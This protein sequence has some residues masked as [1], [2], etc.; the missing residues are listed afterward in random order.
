MK[1]S[2]AAIAVVF[3][4][5]SAAWAMPPGTLTTLRA[6]QALSSAEADKGLPV[7]F[8]ATVT[9]YHKGAYTLFMQ[10]GGVGTFVSPK[11]DNVMLHPGD[12]VFVRG[13][14][15]GSFH[16]IVIS[17]NIT[18]LR[19]GEMPKPVPATFDELIRGQRDCLMV[20]VR[21]VIRA[22]DKKTD[23][24]DNYGANLQMLTEGGYIQVSVFNSTGEGLAD[25]LD[26]EVEV[27]GVA[28]GLFDGKMQAH[29][30]VI[31]VGTSADIKILKRASA[32]PWSLPVTP[33]GEIITGFHITDRTQ[34]VR[35]HG[36]ITY[37]QPGTSV[38][39]QDGASS[40]WI[41]TWTFQP[42]KVGDVVDATG[43]P[44]AHNGFLAVTRGEI[45]DSHIQAPVTPLPTT[46]KQLTQ[47]RH[48]IDLVSLEARV[49][50]EARGGSQDE[51]DLTA[52][53]QLF[54]AI[55][56]H[57]GGDA[58][59]PPMK[60]I[61]IGS[62]VR[63]T[64]ICITEDSNPFNSDVGFDILMRNFDDITVV[65][66]PS[67]INT[68]NLVVAISLLLI[69]VIAVGAWGWFLRKRVGQ[70]TATLASM[71][72][73]EQR[74]SHILE[75]ING[76]APLAEILKDIS[77][78]VSAMLDG[79]LCWCEMENE[80]AAGLRP[81]HLDGMRVIQT[82]I[83]GH[84]SALLGKFFAAFDA[85]SPRSA[86]E[87]EALSVGVRLASLAIET[88]KLFSDL[89]RRSEFDLLTEI[90]NRFSLEKSLTAQIEMAQANNSVFGLIYIDLDKFKQINDRYGHHIGDL[91]L[92]ESARRMKNQLRGGD[93]LARLG[94]DE[95]AALVSV[96]RKRAEA[97]EIA[98]R[99]ERCF[100]EPFSLEGNLI[101]GSA[102]VG[103]A[104]YPEDG[105]TGDGLLSAADDAMYAV[106]RGK[107]QIEQSL[108]PLSAR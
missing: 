60:Q 39:L 53:G 106:K 33:M 36:T 59:P 21:G 25:L 107:R 43:F 65:A 26:A 6:I 99:M 1:R 40:L 104:L 10:D 22:G 94:G 42:M 77:G 51:Y 15:A 58:A 101:H 74:R 4:F 103:F 16:P 30:V 89:R 66:R 2:I 54:S 93:V 73:F 44:E 47:S 72:L 37:Y 75:K 84:S 69:V 11:I 71:A 48:I 29:G 80:P 14:T 35:V 98:V 91:Y 62:K 3:S 55:Y 27:T 12:R 38:V 18:V 70:Q 28:G 90:H 20:T 79:A 50:T 8:E 68:Y 83:S 64:G 61:P 41:S 7:A 17:E 52:D 78:L 105:S 102:S 49:V 95:F 86:Q 88:R 97:V 87:V 32:S 46:R 85:Q 82:E 5:V 81:A 57:P 31:S 96:V 100:D 56:R 13:K 92:Q 34:R 23:S 108:A 45:L 63:V 76:S 67:L 9:Y 24:S 19:H